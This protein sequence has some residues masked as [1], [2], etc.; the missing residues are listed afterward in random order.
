VVVPPPPAQKPLPPKI[1]PSPPPPP[2]AKPALPPAVKPKPPPP[3]PKP[4]VKPVPPKVKP[5][6]PPPPVYKWV[7]WG[8]AGKTSLFDALTKAAPGR[9]LRDHRALMEGHVNP[10]YVGKASPALSYVAGYGL[11]PGLGWFDDAMNGKYEFGTFLFLGKDGTVLSTT[12]GDL[13]SLYWN[14]DVPRWGATWQNWPNPNSVAGANVLMFND[15]KV[16]TKIRYYRGGPANHTFA[17][18]VPD[19]YLQ[20]FSGTKQFPGKEQDFPLVSNKQ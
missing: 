20:A 15:G 10:E 19:S 12:G 1:K 11:T 17:P 14:P 3:P 6:P 18:L 8:G 13:W 2:P 9:G 5:A 4:K 7:K 16:K